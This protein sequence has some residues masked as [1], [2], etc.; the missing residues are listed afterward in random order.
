[1]TS[2]EY[3]DYFHA[4]PEATR[5]RLEPPQKS[6]F[7]GINAEL[8]NEIFDLL[9]QKSLDGPCPHP[10]AHQH[11][12][13]G[14]ATIS[15]G[16]VHAG[17]APG[18]AGAQDF[19]LRHRGPGPGHRLPLRG[20]GVPRAGAAT[21]SRWDGA[22]PL[23]RAPATTASTSTGQGIFL[24]NAE[25][26]T[27]GFTSPDLGMARVPQLVASSASCSAASTTRSRRPSRSRSSASDEPVDGPSC[28]RRTDPLGTFALRPLDPVA[29]A[30]LL[31][32]WVTHPKAAFWLMQDADDRRTSSRVHEDRRRI[33]TTTP[34]SACTTATP[35]FLMERY[36]PARVELAASTPPSPATSACTSSYAPTDT[37]VHG[38]TRAVITTVMAALFADPATRR[39]V[40]EPDVRNT[41]VHA[42]NAAVGFQIVGPV[43]QAREDRPC[44]ASA[45]ASTYRDRPTGAR[46]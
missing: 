41:A 2:P 8:I 27:H 11:R 3:I 14:G 9:Y 18:G 46:R 16:C 35:A 17:A 34:S 12:A 4:L 30:A 22:R 44:S 21:G 20:A 42:L 7:K 24:Q 28:S 26:H 25:L 6:L 10:A 13:G 29:D 5:Y 39:V 36:D 23:R 38:F 37:P 15:D 43:A 33:R 31:H 1:M 45:P 40:V 32:G 19:A